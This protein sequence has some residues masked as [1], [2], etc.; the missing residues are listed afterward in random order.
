MH[1][2]AGQI[3]VADQK[4]KFGVH[5]RF[6]GLSLLLEISRQLRRSDQQFTFTASWAQTCVHGKYHT[7][8]RICSECLH[9]A[10]GGFG[11]RVAVGIF[12]ADKQQVS[13]GEDVKLTAAQS[14]E[15]EHGQISRSFHD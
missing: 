9:H 6:P 15:C 11:C 13:V 3:A 10:L 2:A 1:G 12:C 8:L 4:A 7:L 14:S 5:Q